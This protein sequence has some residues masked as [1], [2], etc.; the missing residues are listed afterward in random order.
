M[1]NRFCPS[2]FKDMKKGFS[3]IELLIAI[4]VFAFL[5]IGVLSMTSV[6]IH[7]NSF[8]LHHTKALQLA[9]AGMELLNRVDYATQLAGYN[10]VVETNIQNYGGFQRE[11]IVEWETDTSRIAVRVFWQRTGRNSNPIILNS[12]RTR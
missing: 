2:R 12:L 6:Q 4:T 5:V 3:L 9:E 1:F 7:S 10:G 8:L 11:Y